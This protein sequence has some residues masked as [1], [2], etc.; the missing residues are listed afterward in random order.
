MSDYGGHDKPYPD[1]FPLVL[2]GL[3]LVPSALFVLGIIL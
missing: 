1:W 3:V 2:G